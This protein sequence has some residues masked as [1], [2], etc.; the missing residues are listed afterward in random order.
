MPP[1]INQL[2]A[3]LLKDPVKVEVTPESPTV[4]KI[5]QSLYFTKK[6]NK[7]YLLKHVLSDDSIRTA[8]VFTRT[9]HGADKL[10]KF[11]NQS[12]I[13]AQ[14]IHGNKSQGARQI[15]LQNFKNQKTR[16]LVATDIAAR[17]ID[18]DELTHVVNFELPHIPETY[19]HRIGRTGRAGADGHALSFCDYEE[20]PLLKDIQKLILKT[21]P[22]VDEHPYPMSVHLTDMSD[23]AQRTAGLKPNPGGRRGRPIFRPAKARSR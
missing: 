13:K 12:G 16:V 15:A 18:I 4:D 9:K 22:I 21:I 1:E 3:Q 17:G 10:T 8:L 2:A 23:P 20:K 14:A 6:E 7:R 19:V 11:L 5:Q